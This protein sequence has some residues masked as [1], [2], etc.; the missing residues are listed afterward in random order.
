MSSEPND[1]AGDKGAIMEQVAGGHKR[2][3]LD[4]AL[5]NVVD[6][7]RRL[8]L[9]SVEG[10]G[11]LETGAEPDGQKS[12]DDTARAPCS[13]PPVGGCKRT[14][15]KPK[16]GRARFRR[17][18]ARPQTP[19][20]VQ[21]LTA[22]LPVP[23][24]P[25]PPSPRCPQ[26][27]ELCSALDRA[28]DIVIQSGKT[29]ELLD[30]L[31]YEAKI[32]DQQVILQGRMQ[33]DV[34]MIRC[35]ETEFSGRSMLYLTEAIRADC[36]SQHVQELRNRCIRTLKRHEARLM[37]LGLQSEVDESQDEG[38]GKGTQTDIYAYQD[39]IVPTLV[40]FEL[41]LDVQEPGPGAHKAG[42]SGAGDGH[43]GEKKVQD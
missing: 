6:L 8:N 19:R 28:E 5:A 9:T 21:C 4:L 20:G 17:T 33:R 3:A 27:W 30:Q 29:D 12:G 23:P 2:L 37:N 15:L 10:Y 38:N 22:H 34:E 43:Q 35:L 26:A 14:Y 41:P 31:L 42:R 25:P 13:V 36:E 40:D 7:A 18:E 39:T 24:P 11:C 32:I 16:R 1:G